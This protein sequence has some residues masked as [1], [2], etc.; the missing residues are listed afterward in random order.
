MF[1]TTKQRF[2]DFLSSSFFSLLLTAVSMI[3]SQLTPLF[4]KLSTGQRNSVTFAI[5]F[6]GLSYSAAVYLREVDRRTHESYL[7]AIG[8]KID[9]HMTGK[10]VTIHSAW[11]N[12]RFLKILSEVQPSNDKDIQ[13]V[14]KE[15][16]R[17]STTGFSSFPEDELLSLI[18]RGVRIKIL[19][20]NPERTEIV[21]ARNEG[22][23]DGEKE[24]HALNAIYTQID[25]LSN[26]QKFP[27]E[28]ISLKVSNLMPFGFVLHTR[29]KAVLGLLWSMCSYTRGPMIEIDSTEKLW[30]TLKDDWNV[31]WAAG[32]APPKLTQSQKA[33]GAGG[34]GLTENH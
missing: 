29:E 18:H 27:K 31:R 22:R 28:K 5:G 10:G 3:F 9:Q 33:G 1:E 13:A 14:D 26:H 23:T 16:V 20:L 32:T 7:E 17:I 8:K 4:T 12:S 6:L 15:D 21:R 11:E 25:R 19:M 34:T 24:A 2:V 30:K